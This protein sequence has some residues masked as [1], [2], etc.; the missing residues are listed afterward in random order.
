MNAYGVQDESEE[1]FRLV[2]EVIKAPRANITMRDYQVRA[3]DKIMQ[4]FETVDTTM[5]VMPTGT[6]KTVLFSE[7]IRRFHPRKAMVIAHREEL[8]LQAQSK[9]NHVT[10]FVV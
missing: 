2:P 4:E 7:I 5:I 6:G 10:G 9:I 3:A 8:I 1:I